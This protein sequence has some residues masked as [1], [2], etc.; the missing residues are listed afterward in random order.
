MSATAKYEVCE[1][2]EK[3]DETEKA[4]RVRVANLGDFKP[5]WVPKSIAQDWTGI[6]QGRGTVKLPLW[7]IIKAGIS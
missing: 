4:V 6:E 5:A 7:W 3:T 1:W 2:A